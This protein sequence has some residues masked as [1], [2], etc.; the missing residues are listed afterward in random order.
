MSSPL[1]LGTLSIPTNTY[2][3]VSALE[4]HESL[5]PTVSEQEMTQK[6]HMH[7]HSSMSNSFD[8]A[9]GSELEQEV[10]ALGGY[11]SDFE[12]SDSE[13]EDNENRAD[14]AHCL[15]ITENQIS[16][17][18]LRKCLAVNVPNKLPNPKK[19]KLDP[20]ELE[21]AFA[22]IKC[23]LASAKTSLHAGSG[24]LE[25]CHVCTIQAT[26]FSMIKNG[27]S[28][29]FASCIAAEAAMFVPD[30]GSHLVR[31][32]VQDWIASHSLPKSN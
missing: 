3:T 27:S 25:A 8:P 21:S 30:W 11:M 9:D 22:D 28:F 32:W 24:G 19:R 14:T 7:N 31:Q 18:S 6:K 1:A 23:H 26:L 16:G 10:F 20:V 15:S 29:T 17:I 2:S 12:Q 5:P 4:S 13:S